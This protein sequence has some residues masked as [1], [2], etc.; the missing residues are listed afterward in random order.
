MEI[1]DQVKINFEKKKQYLN[2][3][4]WHLANHLKQNEFQ[5]TGEITCIFGSYAEVD[6][7]YNVPQSVLEI[8]K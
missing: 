2:S 8:I 4:P 1:G 7:F 3:M 5:G 6:H